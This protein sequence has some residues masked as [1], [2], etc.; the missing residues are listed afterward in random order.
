[1][2]S[3]SQRPL[4]VAIYFR[5]S[6]EKDKEKE[7]Q[8]SERRQKER[9]R[10][11]AVKRG[12]IIEFCEG[13]KAVSGDSEKPVLNELKR[14]VQQ[15]ELN[16]DLVFVDAWD[17]LTRKDSLEYSDDIRWIREAG[18]SISI[19]KKGCEILDLNNNQTLL[20][21]QM[22]VYAANQEL[23][24]KAYRIVSSTI[25][26]AKNGT[27]GFTNAPLGFDKGEEVGTLVPNED[28][29]HVKKMFKHFYEC[30]NLS[31]CVPILSKAR[32]YKLNGKKPETVQVKQILR[33][34]IY[35][36]QRVYGINGPGKHH[37][38]R[39]ERSNGN[40]NTN[41]MKE[42]P[43][44]TDV[45]DKVKPQI[46]KELF[47]EVQKLLDSNKVNKPRNGRPSVYK[48]R[49]KLVCDKCG[50]TMVGETKYNKNNSYT[51]Y[52]CYRSKSKK[53]GCTPRKTIRE[54]EV[55]EIIEQFG[56]TLLLNDGLIAHWYRISFKKIWFEKQK[57]KNVPR[58][59]WTELEL[60]KERVQ[61][62]ID[63]FV[64]RG[65][66]LFS[67]DTIEK[68]QREI[69]QEEEALLEKE[70]V[71][72]SD[73]LLDEFFR[74]TNEPVKA[75]KEGWTLQLLFKMVLSNVKEDIEEGVEYGT[76]EFERNSGAVGVAIREVLAKQ[77]MDGDF[78]SY[79]FATW[80]LKRQDSLNLF[81]HFE[82]EDGRCHYS[83][84]K[85]KGILSRDR[86]KGGNKGHKDDHMSIIT[87]FLNRSG[88]LTY[89]ISKR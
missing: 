53:L 84:W 67:L 1:M 47:H 62:M 45:S 88:I 66:R 52:V 85:A 35:I 41:R 73:P 25:T 10:E 16:I 17:R 55:D 81:L 26:K 63:S 59:R 71:G 46:K 29:K 77:Y 50:Y 42:A 79:D 75:G 28:I 14:K 11:E 34:P 2:E 5:Y 49:G 54:T 30:R 21:L 40:W 7:I 22:E 78:D 70:R 57:K 15:G 18:A 38:I 74:L 6:R 39:G 69:I 64:N 4:K 3:I 20:L 72:E 87:L 31:D 44:C 43:I 83:G 19:L 51:N 32:R 9:L 65:E 13:D 27:L 23:K 8:D 12:W 61:M 58:S 36:G 24:D 89:E 56:A 76:E 86:N 37:Q 48:Y 33:N 60:K 68:Y 80:F 82:E